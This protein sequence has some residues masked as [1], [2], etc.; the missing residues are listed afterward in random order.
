MNF[1][2][3]DFETA[4]AKRTSACSIG[5]VVVENY[6]IVDSQ[7][8]LIKPLPNYYNAM[9]IDIHGITPEMTESAP[10]FDLRWSEL[11]QLLTKYPLLA[12]NAAFDFTVLRDTLTAYHQ[13]LPDIEFYCSLILSRKALPNLD[14]YGLSA[15][16]DHFNIKL[17][18]HNAESDAKAAAIIALKMLEIHGSESLETLTEKM[19]SKQGFM[20][21]N[22]SFQNFGNGRPVKKRKTYQFQP[23]KNPNPNHRFYNKHVVFT[24]KLNEINRKEAMQKVVSVGGKVFPDM[25]TPQTDFLVVGQQDFKKYGEGFK[26]SKLKTAEKYKEQ[27]YPL[28]IM[29]ENEFLLSVE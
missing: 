29:G 5:I 4:N 11:H 24:G 19:G 22:G 21:S 3:I 13:P 14:G 2:A 17:D 7:H 16:S 25:L 27:G 8:H 6:E 28:F 12:H 15:L 10:T 18:H 20:K 1:I 23:P 9:N 26:S